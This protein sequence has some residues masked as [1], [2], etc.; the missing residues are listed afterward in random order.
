MEAKSDVYDCLVNRCLLMFSCS[1]ISGVGSNSVL[2]ETGFAAWLN[3]RSQRRII[4]TTHILYT[5]A[6]ERY[7]S[8]KGRTVTSLTS[9]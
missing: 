9:S 4:W 3:K 7:N 2:R 1:N 8:A 5:I 6:T